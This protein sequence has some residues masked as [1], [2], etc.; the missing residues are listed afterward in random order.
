MARLIELSL[1]ID[2][3]N[4]GS[5]SFNET[6]YLVSATA[7]EEMANPNESVFSSNGFT[8]ELT[9]TLL[10]KNRRF[11]PS[12]SAVV[13]SGGLF[14]YLQDG[15][16]YGTG[17]AVAA[18]LGG[19]S[20]VLFQG[21]IKD[22]SENTRTYKSMGTVTIRCSGDDA[23]VL[24]QKLNTPA[25]DTKTFFELGK[26]EGQ[27]IAR[28]LE[29]A[30]M[31]DGTDFVS[32]DYSGGTKTIDRGLFTIPWYWLDGDSPIDDCWRLAAAC[33]GRFYFNTADSKFYYKNAQYLGFGT[34]STSQATITESNCLRINPVYK[35]KELYKS[36]KVTARQRR[37]GEEEV[38]WEPDEI[39]RI[40]PGQTITL[41]AKLTVPVYEFTNLKVIATNTGGFQITEDLS[42][43][44]TYYSQSVKFVI[45]N[46][47]I[48]HAFL[49]TFQLVGRAIEGGES[50]IY[51][52]AS[53]NTSFWSNRDGKERSVSDNPY[54]QTFAQAEA[55]AN[56][57]IW[58][59]SYFNNQIDV[60]GYKGTAFLRVGYRVT[61]D[62]DSLNIDQDMIITSTTWKISEGN[63][64][65]S[66]KCI[67][68]ES[69]YH[70]T[71]SSYFLIG[72]DT[73]NDTK[74][75]FH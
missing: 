33:A 62:S 28:T 25:D 4:S 73:G 29:L 72:T 50:S 14:E 43:T 30:G 40:L 32:Q 57:L 65:Q 26:D 47:G 71:P 10:N 44:A 54:V 53:P 52:V 48:Y 74:R 46:N 18:T 58:R 16:F 70:Q 38:L 27:L 12:A 41:H 39:M 1:T 19:V 9:L 67:N 75:Y 34:S 51:E 56:L 37:I 17:V 7:N 5:Y 55:I 21:R 15:K 68:G 60:E 3:G 31:V 22:I 13:A 66:F 35:D 6:G 45:V 8:S 42:V 20:H 61:I 36:I 63:M 11:S 24:N 49:R 59:Q 69:L 23:F 64:E 2:W